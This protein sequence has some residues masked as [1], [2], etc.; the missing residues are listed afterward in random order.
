[1]STKK[2]TVS[3]L[4]GYRH[5]AGGNSDPDDTSDVGAPGGVVG[6][7][8]AAQAV[9]GHRVRQV[10]PKD[11]IPHPFNDPKRSEEN[12]GEKWPVLLQ[13]VQAQGVRLPALVVTRH[14]FLAARPNL[15]DTLPEGTYVV[16][17]GHRRAAAAR[18]AGLT[19]MPAA[20]DDEVMKNNGDLDLMALENIGRE[21]LDPMAEA[22]M[23][24]RYSEEVGLTQEKIADR[25]GFNQTTVSRRLALLLLGEEAVAAVES[26]Q[27]SA[28]AAAALAGTLPYGPVRAWQKAGRTG[29]QNSEERRQDQALALA[30]ILN[31]NES[32][33]RAA[34][35]VRDERTSRRRAAQLGIKVVSDAAVE[36]GGPVREVDADDADTS[37][38]VGTIDPVTGSLLLWGT[39]TT[40][41]MAADDVDAEAPPAAV[42]DVPAAEVATTES[43][44]LPPRKPKKESKAGE[45]VT[46]TAT[47]PSR[48]DGAPAEVPGDRD[49]AQRADAAEARMAACASAV[50]QVPGKNDLVEILAA[51]IAH[52]IDTSSA[53]VQAQ[54]DVWPPTGDGKAGGGSYGAHAA[55]AWRRV[56]A[57]YEVAAAAAGEHW[58]PAQATYVELLATRV[59]S[60]QPTAWERRV[61]HGA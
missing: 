46:D 53:R 5:L 1:M 58:G 22:R 24:A 11:L 10:D 40:A 37:S 29:E 19:S 3:R 13:S 21:D 34:E 6:G 49:A 52:G 12:A 59:R 44:P 36:L 16:I 7:L 45:K 18:A 26:G 8:A 39:T 30:R 47:N 27:L 51:A 32:A 60:Y 25:L 4:G 43:N 55:V 41:E 57:G 50:Q 28:T 61:M 42:P 56:L 38:V 15:A 9:A 35:R 17:Y 31:G 48:S 33:S 23:F 20:V 54:A 2:K 14:A